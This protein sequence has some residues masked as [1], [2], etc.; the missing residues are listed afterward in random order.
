MKNFGILLI[1]LL[2]SGIATASEVAEVAKKERER[3]E[4]TQQQRKP[5]RVFTNQDI[6]NLKSSLAFEANQT[7]AIET[8]PVEQQQI[9]TLPAADP[10]AGQTPPPAPQEQT[11]V[12]EER[13]Q[14]M[15]QLKQER[16][17]LE[18]RAKDAQ[19]TINQGGGYHTRNIGS[20]FK[21]KREAEAR[22]R[23]IDQEL[24]KQKE[25]ED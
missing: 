24:E 5:A 12:D 23:E 2:F 4:A 3:R 13:Q 16:E 6:Q 17:E 14:E 25:E 22:I 20:Q 18:Q 21:T 1:V 19:Q 7:D 11:Q 10:N 9:T 15:E 8:P